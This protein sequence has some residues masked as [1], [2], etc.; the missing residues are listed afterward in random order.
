MAQLEAA[1]HSLHAIE[2]SK[3]SVAPEPGPA[4]ADA[5][6]VLSTADQRSAAAA[7]AA[8]AAAPA[9]AAAAA[10]AAA[11]P[12]VAASGREADAQQLAPTTAPFAR[13]NT[14]A[15]ES[16]AALSGLLPGDRLVAFGRVTA[17]NH[18][19]LSALVSAVR[20]SVNAPLTLWVQ[21]D[22]SAQLLALRLTPRAWA[23][24]G[25]LGCHILPL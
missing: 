15:P 14:V 12:P 17:S 10:A 2:L 4:P 24:Q 19:G 13:V 20:D 21:R 22:G 23:G 11:V 25:L 6:S 5:R 16:P 18:N 7:A 3:A 1:L 9:A 8:A